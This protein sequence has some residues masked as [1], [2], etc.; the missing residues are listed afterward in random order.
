MHESPD[1]N[2]RQ[3]LDCAGADQGN[4]MML[5]AAPVSVN[6]ACALWRPAPRQDQT[7]RSPVEIFAAKRFDCDC[8]AVPF[9][10]SASAIL[11]ALRASS[12]VKTP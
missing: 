12:T 7:A 1:I 3:I 6:R 9:D 8:A 5:N 4:N 2:W 11:A 10:T